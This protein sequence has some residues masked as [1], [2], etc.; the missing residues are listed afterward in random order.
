MRINFFEE[1]PTKRNLEKLKGIKHESTLYLAGNSL[2]NFLCLRDK[3]EKINSNISISF[4]PILNSSYWI[5]P[6]SYSHEID[7]LFHDL[8]ESDDKLKVLLD[9]EI[10]IMN[11]KLFLLNMPYFRKNKKKIKKLFENSRKIEITTAEYPTFNKKF[12]YLMEI[13]G[14]SF[15]CNKFTHKKIFMFYSSLYPEIFDFL[16]RN[17]II[18]Q[19]IND[20]FQV[21]LGIIKE[22]ILTKRGFIKKRSILSPKKLDKGLSFLNSLGIQE[23]TIYRLGGLNKDYIEI[24]EKYL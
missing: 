6:F 23:A 18:N 11:P 12:L 21:G 9:L 22:G 1:F 13:L 10:P 20:N 24:I 19:C 7:R 17:F 16:F 5:S 4:W 3:I 8:N 14:L 2:E 15:D